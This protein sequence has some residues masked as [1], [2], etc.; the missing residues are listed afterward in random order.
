[1]K[2]PSVTFKPIDSSLI[3]QDVSKLP[4]ARKRIMELLKKGS[5]T[6]L[7]SASKSWSL[8]FQL[9]PTSFNASPKYPERLASVS[10]EKTLLH[11]NAF[12]PTARTK[13]TGEDLELPAGF[14]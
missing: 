7:S 5:H 13:G 2:L 3:P 14:A 11:P 8:D 12:D 10:F 6:S 9:S 1:M 4:R